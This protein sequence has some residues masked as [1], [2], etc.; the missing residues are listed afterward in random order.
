LILYLDIYIYISPLV[1]EYKINCAMLSAPLILA[2][3]VMGRWEREG[4][5]VIDFRQWEGMM[6]EKVVVVAVGVC[7]A[8]NPGLSKMIR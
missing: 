4:R 3:R 2:P 7:Q 5:R 6:K 1:C 8:T